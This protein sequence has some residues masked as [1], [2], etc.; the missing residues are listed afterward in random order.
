LTRLYCDVTSLYD[1]RTDFTH[2]LFSNIT[3]LI[4]EVF[5]LGDGNTAGSV[6]ALIPHLNHLSFEGY[7][8]LETKPVSFRLLQKCRLVRVLV[9][10]AI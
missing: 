4:L 2:P 7:N 1:G 9:Y 5:Y 8:Y 6:F 10:L 3:H